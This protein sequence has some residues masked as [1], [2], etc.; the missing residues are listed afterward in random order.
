MGHSIGQPDHP[1]V[2]SDTKTL[3][4]Y[5]DRRRSKQQERHSMR[6]RSE[7]HFLL[8]VHLP[9]D[10]NATDDRGNRNDIRQ[11]DHRAITMRSSADGTWSGGRP[12]VEA[13]HRLSRLAG[14]DPT[15]AFAPPQGPADGTT[16]C[17]ARHKSSRLARELP[18]LTHGPW[19]CGS[20]KTILDDATIGVLISSPSFICCRIAFDALCSPMAI[21]ATLSGGIARQPRGVAAAGLRRAI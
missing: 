14:G 19:V 8:I 13:P 4:W 16:P 10:N 15:H 6:R 9:M 5:Q 20:N 12:S 17:H 3:L 11:R 18:P 7:F 2:T 1:Q 21:I